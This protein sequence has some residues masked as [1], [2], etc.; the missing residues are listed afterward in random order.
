MW[1]TH[2]QTF[3]FL[4]MWLTSLE[5]IEVWWGPQGNICKDCCSRF[6]YFIVLICSCAM[7]PIK[8]LL[9]HVTYDWVHS[10]LCMNCVMCVMLFLHSEWIVSISDRTGFIP[11][12]CW[13]ICTT[14]TVFTHCKCR[15]YW[16]QFV[17]HVNCLLIMF[18]DVFWYFVLHSTCKKLF[19]KI[20][21]YLITLCN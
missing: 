2:K 17:L 16:C 9:L 18:S 6:L 1:R 19:S 10:D 12:W 21:Y 11:W 14:G 20:A 4:F 15:R 5:L 13:S 7:I 3:H 8:W